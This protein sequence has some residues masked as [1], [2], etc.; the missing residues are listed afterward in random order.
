MNKVAEMDTYPI[1]NIRDLYA[2][3][4]GGDL[5]TKL[6]MSKVCEAYEQLSLY[7]VSRKYV[8]IN[9]H[10]RTIYL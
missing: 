6:D 1:P 8:T 9:T 10:K 2:K 7:V 5:F 4:S 3:L